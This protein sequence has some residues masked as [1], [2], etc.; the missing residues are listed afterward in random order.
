MEDVTDTVFR[1]FIASLAPPDVFFT[2][3]TSADG[4]FSPGRESVIQR[5]RFEP[6]EHPIVAQIWGLEP[7]NYYEAAKLLVELGFDGIDINMGCPVQKIIKK[8]ACSALIDNPT[9]AQELFQATKEGAGTLPVSIK[10]RIGFRKKETE[11]WAEQLLTMNPS[12]LTIHGRV[13][14][15]MSKYPAD[16]EE[17]QKVVD[18]RDQAQSKVVIIGNGDIFSR[19]DIKERRST[20]TVDGFMIARGIFHDPYI[21]SKEPSCLPLSQRPTEHK[22]ELLK[23]HV[24]R[25]Q[26]EYPRESAYRALKKFFKI[27]LSH[28]DGASELRA[29]FIEGTNTYDEFFEVWE[30]VVKD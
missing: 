6:D 7:N 4:L 2:E 15:H 18:L 1:R 27:Y 10:T 5:L 14:K 29:R 22:L 25:A 12:A 16:W 26:K 3:F 30:R 8:G 28:F 24:H 20:S 9:L 13:A 21:F 17:I 19:E 11:R 23:E